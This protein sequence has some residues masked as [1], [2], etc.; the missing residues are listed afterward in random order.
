[1]KPLRL[2]LSPGIIAWICMGACAQPVLAQ[3]EPPTRSIEFET[4]Q[5]TDP[6]VAVSPDGSWLVFTILGHLFR[7]PAAGGSA[8]QLTFGSCYDSDPAI[9]PDGNRIAFVS[10]RDG[11]EGNI[12][13][14][15][16]KSPGIVR[17]TSEP[18]AARP[19]W[20]PDGKSLVYLRM[21]REVPGVVPLPRHSTPDL[22]PAVVRRVLLGGGEPERLTDRPQLVGSVFYLPDGRVGWIVTDLAMG[23]E[24]ARTTTRI[25]AMSAPGRVT[26]LR[27]VEGY[28][29][30]AVPSPTGDGIYVRRFRPILP[31]YTRRPDDLLFVPFAPGAETLVMALARPR[32]WAP[33]L[34]AYERNLYLG[35]AGRLWK[36][37]LPDRIREPLP[38]RAR[39]RLEVREPVPPVE[40]ELAQAGT[41]RSPR[42]ML[43][44][45]LSPDGRTL[46]FGAA[47]YLW[48]QSLSGGPA[49]RLFPSHHSFDRDPAFSPDGRRL[50]FVRGLSM[51][52][53]WGRRDEIM[54]L[55][56]GSGEVRTVAG[57]RAF[58]EPAWSP[59]GQRLAVEVA[60]PGPDDAPRVLL[61]GLGEQETQ[62]LSSARGRNP[63]PH[64]SGDGRGIYFSVASRGRGSVFRL[65][66]ERTAAPEP[67]AVLEKPLARAIVSPDGEWLAFQRNF[68]IWVAR[69]NGRPIGERDVRLLSGDG[70]ASFAF[71]P[72]GSALIYAS[73]TRVWIHAL[74]GGVRREIPIDLQLRQDRP[75]P[76]LLRRVRV[77]DFA[78]GGFGPE[79]AVLLE[80]GQIR[81]I[82]ADDGLRL[83]AATRVIDAGG[84]FAIPGL[85]DMHVHGA[86]A[87]P[88]SFIAY[89][90]TSVRQP[91]NSFK[92]LAAL[93]DRSDASGDAV[94]RQFYSGDTFAGTQPVGLNGPHHIHEEEEAR[95]YVR[96]AKQQGV[97]FL[98]VYWPLSWPLHRA[99]AEEARKH[100]L[101]VVGHGG[102]G[103]EEI[104]KSVILG[105][106][107]LEHSI[108]PSRAYDDVLQLL[109]AAGTRWDPTLSTR[110]NGLLLRAEPERLHDPK[111][112]RFELEWYIRDA[113]TGELVDGIGEHEAR[114][115]FV[116]LLG[117][118]GAAHA[119]G[120]RLLAGT[121]RFSGVS[122]HW[123]LEYLAQAGLAPLDV[124]RIATQEAAT[125][126]GVDDQLGTLAPGKSADL[127][128]LEA[129]PLENIRNTQRIWRV[130]KGGWMFDPER[131]SVSK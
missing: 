86:D 37:E 55:D 39:V 83:P 47:G 21:V 79:T 118:V 72:D 78:A 16:L 100:G 117:S 4:V 15:D 42:A 57:G 53:L 101:P 121:D 85:F 76:L 65:S 51:E 17:V 46:V 10:D 110:G 94:P 20:S 122:L 19:A 120:V 11:S 64:F 50:A 13:V 63:R 70:G 88:A 36:I 98:K 82:G 6:D 40:L 66:L 71:T 22:V 114:G 90:V 48:Q 128:L 92:A 104:V 116:D 9:S 75:P 102:A 58:A 130:I 24:I 67:L 23:R 106:A 41:A 112:R 91:G 125:A 44:P 105:Y 87:N 61:I 5:V 73:G 35:E 14:L 27:T 99:V 33:R 7:L 25:E 60:G 59:D 32:G 115:A 74:H 18:W 3:G 96:R 126:L 31:W 34:A 80:D 52:P 69:L 29:A 26:T 68:E 38:F 2:F 1:M 81:W 131:L 127:V 49:R 77:L 45:T 89:G 95:R 107:S 12:F 108:T 54:V 123:E 97:H 129:N 84:R 113:Q 30:P 56:F 28:A 119:R 8:E 109:A 93:A 62:E 103:V 124:L 43:D 111:L